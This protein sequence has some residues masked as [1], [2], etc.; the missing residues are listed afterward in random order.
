MLIESLEKSSKP[1]ESGSWMVGGLSCGGS[2]I[3]IILTQEGVNRC[4]KVFGTITLTQK[5]M[6]VDV[7]R[8][9]RVNEAGSHFNVFV[10]KHF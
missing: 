7:A 8:F 3:T 2:K 4:C 1:L 5:V 9:D 10:C 6:I